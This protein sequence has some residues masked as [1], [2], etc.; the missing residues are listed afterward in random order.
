MTVF[1]FCLFQYLAHSCHSAFTENNACGVVGR[2]DYYRSC[3]FIQG[4]FKSRKVHLKIGCGRRNDSELCSRLFHKNSVLGEER[5]KGNYLL[6]RIGSNK[7]IE[8]YS[9]RSGSTYCHIYKV[10]ICF[11]IVC[12]FNVISN[13]G[14]YSE[15]SL[16]RSIS[17][18][19]S[20]LCIFYKLFQSFI[21]DSGCGHARISYTVIK[22]L[23]GSYLRLSLFCVF[24]NFSYNR[25]LNAK[26]FHFFGYHK[27]ISFCSLFLSIGTIIA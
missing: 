25:F 1:L 5:G 18:K 12:R 3:F 4:F 20:R 8:G 16:R 9:K 27:N 15:I 2:I 19:G 11:G 24:K 6:V 7:R 17:V 10:R 22:N 26:G 21:Y 14:T 23:V 13:C